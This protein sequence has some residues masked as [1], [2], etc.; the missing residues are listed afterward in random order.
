[1]KWLLL[2]MLHGIVDDDDDDQSGVGVGVD[3]DVDVD[4]GGIVINLNGR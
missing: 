4:V 2:L 3:V 1:M